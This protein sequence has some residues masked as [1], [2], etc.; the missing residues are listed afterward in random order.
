MRFIS[1]VFTLLLIL[2][3]VAFAALNAQTVEVNYFIGTKTLP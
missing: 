2:L 1:G 3:G